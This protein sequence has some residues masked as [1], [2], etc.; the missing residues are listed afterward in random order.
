MIE[1]IAILQYSG[2]V[3]SANRSIVLIGFMGTGKSAVGRLLASQKGWPRFD[4]DEMIATAFKMPISEIFARLGEER[5]REEETAL[6]EKLEVVQP[7][8]IVTGG[9]A[10]MRPKNVT[11][12]RELGRVVCLTADPP[13]LAGAVWAGGRTGLFSRLKIRQKRCNRCSGNE[14]RS[15][16]RRRILRSTPLRSATNRSLNQSAMSLRSPTEVKADL[17]RRAAEIGF[18]DCRIAQAGDPRHAGEFRQWLEAGS[19]ADM[20]WIARGAEKRCDPQKVLTGARSVV[21]LAMNYWQ[22]DGDR[23]LQTAATTRGRIARYAWGDDYH[24]VLEKKLR[25][26]DGFLT[27]A[28]GRQKFYV[29]TGPVLERDFA[30]EAGIGW[31]GK[32]TMLLNRQF[33][34]WFFLAEIFTTLEL[35]S[36]PPQV[37][38]CGSCTRCIDACPT[39]AITAPHQ[40]D[41]RRCISYLTIELKGASRS[42]SGR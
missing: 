18:D 37:A 39:G 5:F 23:G 11:R 30:A 1:V 3:S 2:R 42:S 29:D 41:A 14:S 28:G 33:G 26:L 17:L 15:I 27:A 34:T 36:D 13:T 12:L 35:P 6:L 19:A 9:G 20:D 16:R 25:A 24:D 10:V 38:R 40:L 31:H 7:S 22:G 21:T 32:S 8:I 4:T